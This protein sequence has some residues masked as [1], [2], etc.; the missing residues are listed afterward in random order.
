METGA[1]STVSPAIH[2]CGSARLPKKYE[3]RPEI[4]HFRAF[5]FVS[6]ARGAKR[7][8]WNWLKRRANS[9]PRQKMAFGKGHDQTDPETQQGEDDHAGEELIGLHQAAGL[10]HEGTDSSFRPDHFRGYQQDQCKC[11]RDSEASQDRGKRAGQQD[12]E[13][14]RAR[15]KIEAQSHPHQLTADILDAAGGA[16]R[17]REKYAERDGRDFRRL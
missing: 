6:A 1:I 9:A 11:R 16:D 7:T 17:R 15:R 8:L 5:D 13:D 4:P 2:W 12:L 10:E 14:D 3:N